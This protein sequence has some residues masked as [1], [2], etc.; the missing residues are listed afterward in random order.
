MDLMIVL[1]LS[2]FCNIEWMDG[3]GSRLYCQLFGGIVVFV[4]SYLLE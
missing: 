1:S 2:F 4:R 3:D